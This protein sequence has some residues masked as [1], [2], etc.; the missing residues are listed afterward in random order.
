MAFKPN[1]GS[2]AYWE[3]RAFEWNKKLLK[4]ENKEILKTNKIYKSSFDNIHKELLSFFD[5]YATDNKLTLLEAQQML[6][7]IDMFEYQE[8]IAALR[9][10]YKD[11]QSQFIM[12]EIVKLQ[13]RAK[14]TRLE[15]LLAE[16]NKE[17]IQ[18]SHTTQL[19]LTDML[20]GVYTDV[21]DDAAKLLGATPLVLPKKAI[22]H[23]VEYP[24]NGKMFSDRIWDNKSKLLGFIQ[25]ELTAGLVRGDSTQKISKKLMKDLEVYYFQAERLVRTE[26]NYV[27]NKA[28]EE[29]YKECGI[30]QYQFIAT[31]DSRTSKVCANHDNNIYYLRD[32]KVGTNYPPLHPNCR[33]TVVPYK[34]EWAEK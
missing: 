8:T 16:I 29:V 1:M 31:I 12:D 21:Y 28:S 2:K 4:M 6:D 26:T 24:W 3:E 11:T 13:S 20:T 5:K 9:E 17:L 7:P 14:V 15:A 18:S 23:I 34:K 32:A 25:Q 10:M 30:K 27:Y 33:S 22:Q 19:S